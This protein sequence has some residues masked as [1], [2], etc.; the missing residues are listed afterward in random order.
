MNN[1]TERE[2]VLSLLNEYFEEIEEIEESRVDEIFQRL[3]KI[4]P[5]PNIS[6]YVFYPE[7][8]ELTAEEI[9]EKVFSYKP[10]L[11]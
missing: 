9:V 11:L 4:S 8:E 10:I 7:G 3:E 5:D 1:G 2:E 6:D